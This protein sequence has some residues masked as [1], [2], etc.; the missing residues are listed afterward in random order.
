MLQRRQDQRPVARVALAR[1]QIEGHL[2]ASL[3]HL[4]QQSRAAGAVHFIGAIEAF[5]QQQ[6][7]EME[8]FQRRI[9]R[10]KSR[11]IKQAVGA[12]RVKESALAFGVGHHLGHRGGGGAGALYELAIDMVL[13]EHGGDVVAIVILAN[14]ADRLQRQPGVH[15]GQ[16]QQDIQR[17]AAGGAFAMD[18]FHQPAALRPLPDL[19]D[20]IDQH[21]ACGNNAFPFHDCYSA[22]SYSLSV[23]HNRRNDCAPGCAYFTVQPL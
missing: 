4:R 16:G 9:Q 18:N 11:E 13:I 1:H 12:G 21:V 8:N 22:P 17:R 3:A 7:A 14:Q 20:M 10:L 6:I 19:V 15:F 2:I 5:E 23:A